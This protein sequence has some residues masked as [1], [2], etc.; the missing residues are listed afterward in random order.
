MGI[1]NDVMCGYLARTVVFYHGLEEYDGCLDLQEDRFRTG[2][3]ELIGVMKRSKNRDALCRYCE[4]NEARF[5]ELDEDTVEAIGVMIN[6][7]N[8]NGYRNE[9]GEMN[10]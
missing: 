5:R 1:M 3:R 2:L 4:E 8:L 10:M 6:Y 7:P 9:R